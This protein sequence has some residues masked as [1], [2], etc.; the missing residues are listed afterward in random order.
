MKSAG[1]SEELEEVE[2]E[3]GMIK[4]GDADEQGTVAVAIIAN[5]TSS[6][7]GEGERACT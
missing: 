2:A 1:P 5:I 7:E 6:Y 3:L 4:K